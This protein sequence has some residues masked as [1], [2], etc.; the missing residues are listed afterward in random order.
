MDI[1]N[2]DVSIKLNKFRDEINA[3][4]RKYK[5]GLTVK[6]SPSNWLAKLLKRHIKVSR[7]II[8]TDLEAFITKKEEDSKE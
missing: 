5:V 7:D 2:N 8:I 1:I 3:L 4:M 6:V